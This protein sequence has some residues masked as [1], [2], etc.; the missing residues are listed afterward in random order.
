LHASAAA[1]I[2][3][4]DSIPEA[5]VQAGP[6]G[7]T[8]KLSELVGTGKH[9][10]IGIPGAFTP[11]CSDTH[12]PGYISKRDEFTSKGVDGISVLSVNDAFVMQQWSKSLGAGDKVK[13]IADVDGSATTEMDTGF[14]AEAVF[15]P[16]PRSRRYA[17]LIE[18]GK[19][20]QALMEGGGELEKSSADQMLALL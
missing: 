17:L 12:V 7:E 3:V 9:I 15:G 1:R 2:A 6:P 13:M 20:T 10:L 16:A 14:T 5:A 11:T 4:G 19:V 8:S 18:D